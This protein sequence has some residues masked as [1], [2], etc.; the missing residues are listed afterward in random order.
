MGLQ[1]R[2]VDS[3]AAAAAARQ[4]DERVEVVH[5]SE[6]QATADVDG[7]GVKGGHGCR[8]RKEGGGEGKLVL[9]RG[10]RLRVCFD[11]LFR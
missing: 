1:C 3:H 9:S 4:L 7:A 8:S 11:M 6:R 5:A 10:Y 2:E